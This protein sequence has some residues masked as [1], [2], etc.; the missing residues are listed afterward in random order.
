MRA[1]PVFPKNLSKVYNRPLGENS[2]NLVTLRSQ[3]DEILAEQVSLQKSV[4]R[5]GTDVMIF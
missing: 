4:S 1:F 2:P 5:P 3:K